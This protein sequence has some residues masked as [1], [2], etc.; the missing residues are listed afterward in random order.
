MMVPTMYKIK[1]N[2]T[3]Y[4]ALLKIDNNKK[5]FLI[6]VDDADK[7]LGTLTDGDIRRALIQGLNIKSQVYNAYNKNSTKVYMKDDFANII[8]IFKNSKIKFLP[9]V[10]EVEKLVNIITKSN[11]HVLLLGDIDFGMDYNFLQLEDTLLEHEIYNRPWG[12]YKTT[13]INEHSQSKIIKV[14]PLGVLSL[15]E[16]KHREEYWVVIT[17]IGEVTIGESIKRVGSGDFV[18]IPKACKHRLKNTSEMENLMVAEVQLGDY[19][20]E[21]DI[22][23]HE[24]D[25]GRK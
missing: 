18:Y 16:H 8:E 1:V 23:R 9:I 25:Y 3:I 14:N 13:F 20:G 12:L 19:F 2:D 11:M 22:I 4:D 15:Q 21:D 7:Y 17:G 5:G 6:A 10:D 24:D